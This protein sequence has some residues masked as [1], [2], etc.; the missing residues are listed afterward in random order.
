M[1]D[2]LSPRECDDLERAYRSR[3]IWARVLREFYLDG[4]RLI[5]GIDR[6]VPETAIAAA[7]DL[8]RD[9]ARAGL[10]SAASWCGAR[11]LHLLGYAGESPGEG[12][13]HFMAVG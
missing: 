7:L 5:L 9:A 4:T 8:D 12:L 11:G 3:E 10:A 1:L 13:R 6:S 2:H